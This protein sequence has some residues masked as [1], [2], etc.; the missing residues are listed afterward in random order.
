MTLCRTRRSNGQEIGILLFLVL[1]NECGDISGA[2]AES[3]GLGFWLPDAA[4]LQL[5]LVGVPFSALAPWNVFRNLLLP[6]RWRVFDSL[7]LG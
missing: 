6:L 7:V 5:L 3:L 4:P 1:S 2:A